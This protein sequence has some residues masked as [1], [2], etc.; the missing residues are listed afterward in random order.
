MKKIITII[1]AMI[2]LFAMAQVENTPFEEGIEKT[3]AYVQKIGYNTD[4]KVTYDTTVVKIYGIPPYNEVY[5]HLKA[6]NIT[7]DSMVDVVVEIG[8]E[9]DTML[10]VLFTWRKKKSMPKKLKGIEEYDF[11]AYG[12]Y[13]LVKDGYKN[14]YSVG[15]VGNPN[16]PKRFN[17]DVHPFSFSVNGV[18]Y[19]GWY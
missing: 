15:L 8:R 11:W 17:A 19:S 18:S 5:K 6:K 16:R 9:V 13:H 10:N 3:W 7:D 14:S 4:I 12:N 1:I 2:P